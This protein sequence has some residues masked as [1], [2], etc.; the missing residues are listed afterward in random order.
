M[1]IIKI[2]DISLKSF[3]GRFCHGSGIFRAAICP[4]N[5]PV[6]GL[7]TIIG[8]AK[9][10]CDNE[11]IPM[12]AKGFSQQNFIAPWPINFRRVEKINPQLHG[13]VQRFE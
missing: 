8:K 5:L 11:V 4:G 12:S 2:K 3:Q 13:P 7:I 1:Q 6:V 10:C 9:F